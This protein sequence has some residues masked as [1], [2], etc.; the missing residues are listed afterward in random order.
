MPNASPRFVIA[1]KTGFLGF[2]HP[3]SQTNW[4]LLAKHHREHY[5]N[6]AEGNWQE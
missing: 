3:D 5:W 4:G 2:D 6:E 1:T